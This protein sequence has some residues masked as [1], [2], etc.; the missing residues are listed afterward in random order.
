[1]NINEGKVYVSY[2][3]GG[4]SE[5]LVNKIDQS[6]QQRGIKIIRDKRDL[7]FKSSIK[8][9]MEEIG[10]GNCVIVVVSNKYLRSPSCMFELV[11]VA[12]NQHFRDRIFPIVLLDANIYDPIKRLEYVKYWE[13]K[14]QELADA[15]RNVDP[16]NLQGIQ[17]DMNN[18]HRF[19]AEVSGLASTL[20][21]MNALTPEIH[22]DSDFEA[23]YIALGKRIQDSRLPQIDSRVSN[24]GDLSEESIVEFLTRLPIGQFEKLVFIFDKGGSVPGR[25]AAQSIR[26][27]E[28]LKI[29]YSNKDIMSKLVSEIKNITGID[30]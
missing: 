21:D 11:E 23:L 27:I 29:A 1:M 19:R 14:R 2:A 17:E 8:K 5:E 16:A 4:E 15:I 7:P 3:W 20:R 24:I 30:E 9:F 10:R 6:L 13:N 12:G 28:L 22:G 18:Y 25:E 26:A